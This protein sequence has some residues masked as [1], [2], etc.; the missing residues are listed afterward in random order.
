MLDTVATVRPMMPAMP[1][2]GENPRFVTLHRRFPTIAYL[3]RHAR[4]HVP[5]FAFEVWMGARAPTAASRAIGGQGDAIKLVPR[6]GV[7]H[8]AAAG[9]GRVVWPPLLGANGHRS[10]GRAFDGRAG[11]DQLLAA[12]ARTPRAFIR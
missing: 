10:H 12:A 6:Y 5:A 11:S 3:R 7:S 9:R 4:R 1:F 8:R 2:P